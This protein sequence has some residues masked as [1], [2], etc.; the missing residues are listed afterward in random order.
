[1]LIDKMKSA[2]DLIKRNYD[3]INRVSGAFLILIGVAMMTGLMG[4]LLAI[5]S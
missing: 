5:L 3:I 4:R 2:F 1:M